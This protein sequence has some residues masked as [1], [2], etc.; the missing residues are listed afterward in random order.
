[1]WL[2]QV[3][4]IV[5]DTV[6]FVKGVITRELNAATDNPIVFSEDDSVIS[7]GNFHGEYPAKV[8]LGLLYFCIFPLSFLPP[9]LFAARRTPKPSGSEV[10]L[11]SALCRGIVDCGCQAADYLAIG[12]SELASISER[13]IERLVNHHLSGP[14]LKPD[15]DG[16]G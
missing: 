3:H 16:K 9:V 2:P 4:G 5:H 11:C 6:N 14:R 8:S 10:S 12:I 13:R 1:M 15:A 7:A